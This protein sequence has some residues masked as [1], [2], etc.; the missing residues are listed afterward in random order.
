MR[1][2]LCSFAMMISSQ[3]APGILTEL[4]P[5]YPQGVI[6]IL[7]VPTNVFSVGLRSAFCTGVGGSY[8][9]ME[10]RARQLTGDPIFRKVASS[11]TGSMSEWRKLVR[12]TRLHFS[13][14]PSKL[15]DWYSLLCN[16]AKRC[17]DFLNKSSPDPGLYD[18]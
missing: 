13:Y 10:A 18:L 7:R 1:D 16:E 9:V 2:F 15:C 17:R 4:K 3:L 14:L 12:V 6:A 5:F 11:G 8:R